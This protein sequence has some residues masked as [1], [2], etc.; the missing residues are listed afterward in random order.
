VNNDV[1]QVVKSTI[2]LKLMLQRK[3]HNIQRTTF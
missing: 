3:V 2:F 1:M